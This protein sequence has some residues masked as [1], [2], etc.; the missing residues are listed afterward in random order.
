[1][2]HFSRPI[3]LDVIAEEFRRIGGRVV[4]VG[5]CVRDT[6]LGLPVAEFDAEVFGL[7]SKEALCDVLAKFGPVSEVGK[8]FGVMKLRY[9]DTLYDFSLPRTESKVVPGH[10]GFSVVTYSDLSFK[11]AAGRRDFTINAMGYELETGVLLDPYD[12]RKDL[13]AKKLRHVSEAFSEDSLRVLRAMQFSGRFDLTLDPETAELCRSISLDDLP[14]ERIWDEFKKLFLLSPRPSV[15]LRVAADLKV[16]R[17][18]SMIEA[19]S[20]DDFAKTIEFVDQVSPAAVRSEADLAVILAAFSYYTN[21][22]KDLLSGLVLGN[23]L[24]KR[25]L[26]LRDAARGLQP[27]FLVP[28]TPV[29]LDSLVRRLAFQVPISELVKLVT[30][31]NPDIANLIESIAKSIGVYDGPPKPLLTGADLIERGV[32]PGLRLGHLLDLAFEAYL[33]GHLHTLEETLDWLEQEGLIEKNKPLRYN[34]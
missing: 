18:F 4:L 32:L 17:L 13:A 6:L 15:G 24:I 21:A 10:R 8:S 23:D 5:G 12:G 9:G 26:A 31:L 16:G 11:S 34:P 25:S 22:P 28:H 33:D 7:S 30:G 3:F 1:M 14:K 20:S 19:L 29:S 2:I 27:F